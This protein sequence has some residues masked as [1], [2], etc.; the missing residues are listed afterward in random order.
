MKLLEQPAPKV[1]AEAAPLPTKGKSKDL[2]VTVPEK[3]TAAETSLISG[4]LADLYRDS[5]KGLLSRSDTQNIR[6][7]FDEVLQ[8][9]H[10]DWNVAIN[11]TVT[12]QIKVAGAS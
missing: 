2:R 10:S 4:V 7:A 3:E 1:T 9:K 8:A 6:K 11:E 12:N 5:P